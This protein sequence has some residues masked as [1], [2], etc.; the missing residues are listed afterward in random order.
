MLSTLFAFGISAWPSIRVALRPLGLV[1]VASSM[2][3]LTLVVAAT[4]AR[5][6]ARTELPGACAD[7]QGEAWLLTPDD[8]TGNDTEVLLPHESSE[9]S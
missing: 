3:L 4:I 9:P 7:A 1:L 6:T 5:H 2:R 8:G